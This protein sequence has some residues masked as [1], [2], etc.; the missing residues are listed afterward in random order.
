[1]ELEPFMKEV[2]LVF[3]EVNLAK[4]LYK[5]WLPLE[6]LLS[7]TENDTLILSTH[8]G[9]V[10]AE[11]QTSAHDLISTMG[12][13]AF[14]FPYLN[15]GKKHQGK[16]SYNLT[17]NLVCSEVSLTEIK[18]SGEK[19]KIVDCD[20]SYQFYF[21]DRLVHSQKKCNRLLLLDDPI[22]K[23]W[24]TPD[25]MVLPGKIVPLTRN[26][27][28]IPKCMIQIFSVSPS[29]N[30]VLISMDRVK[31]MYNLDDGT[32]KVVPDNVISIS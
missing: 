24:C 1:M 30:K 21:D 23:V 22:P 32:K 9:E 17:Y 5:F 26:A 15:L 7:A 25:Y 13:M 8:E 12:G 31:Y 20:D 11:I 6:Y 14:E 29:S 3:N 19:I 18:N 10:I 28:K 27:R 16:K 4:L 2:D